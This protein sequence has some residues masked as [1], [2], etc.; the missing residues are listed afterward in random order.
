[1]V[2]HRITRLF[3]VP[4]TEVRFPEVVQ[5]R[6]PGPGVVTV[7]PGFAW[8]GGRACTRESGAT[9]SRMTA[10]GQRRANSPSPPVDETQA[11][12]FL[13]TAHGVYGLPTRQQV[14]NFGFAGL[15]QEGDEHLTC[16]AVGFPPGFSIREPDGP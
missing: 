4:H 9:T 5:V 8:R 1:M 16:P 7:Q 15:I 14:I 10:A 6:V 3:R 12:L 2:T 13:D 11:C